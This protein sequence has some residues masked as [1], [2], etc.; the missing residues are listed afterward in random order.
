MYDYSATITNIVDGDTYDVD[1]DLGF[2]IHIHERIRILN[3][4][5]PEKR[6]VEKELGQICTD[7][8]KKHF[9]EK[10]VLLSSKEEIKE[11]KTDS[12]GR[13]LCQIY[14]NGRSIADIFSALG[15]NKYQDNY[16]K[17]NVYK[18]LET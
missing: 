17:E 10:K 13:W 8:A 16:K 18:L 1:I 14:I 5:T 3:L 9:L 12:F 7:Y 2:H 4:D 11:P 6:G 15:C